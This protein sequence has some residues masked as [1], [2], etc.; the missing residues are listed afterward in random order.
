MTP[1]PPSVPPGGKPPVGVIQSSL[2]ALVALF[3]SRWIL[4]GRVPP[5]PPGP[6]D[7]LELTPPVQAPF[8]SRPPL[9]PGAARPPDL[10]GGPE[11][12]D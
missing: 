10:P 9:P 8:V 1:S 5:R 11:T 4:P 6:R 12:R 2:S 3:R 7:E